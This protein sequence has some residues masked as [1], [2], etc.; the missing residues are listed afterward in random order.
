MCTARYRRAGRELG[1]QARR[2]GT[3]E[4][5]IHRFEVG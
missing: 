4:P 5:R 3:K 1:Q 2:F